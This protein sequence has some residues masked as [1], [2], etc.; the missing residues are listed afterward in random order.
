VSDN[1]FQFQ[2]IHT[3]AA[4]PQER[5][6]PGGGPR[7]RIRDEAGSPETRFAQAEA[8]DRV[9]NR[10]RDRRFG[11]CAGTT[12]EHDFAAAGGAL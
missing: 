6:L 3:F 9:A 4:R 7:S 8:A 5:G 2:S 1:S 10:W 11:A 12:I